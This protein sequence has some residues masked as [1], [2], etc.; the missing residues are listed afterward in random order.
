MMK[1]EETVNILR[2][3][4]HDWM[5][6]VQ[7]LMGYASMGKLDK[8]QDKLR[9]SVESAERERKL[10]NLNIPR[11]TIWLMSFNWHYDNF[12]IE[13]NVETEDKEQSIND[14][15]LHSQFLGIMDV[16][17]KYGMKFELYHGTI[18]IRPSMQIKGAEINLSFSGAFEQI[19]RLKQAIIEKD[20]KYKLKIE[21]LSNGTYAC[22]IS[23]ICS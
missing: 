12:R 15:L 9:E 2:H 16:F 1:E 14:Q 23:W 21:Q 3:Y 5:N 10:Q 6:Q 7:L 18:T 20:D 13:Y 22:N 4:R 19:D 17:S 8:V 11:T